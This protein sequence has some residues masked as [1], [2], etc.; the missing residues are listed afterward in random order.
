LKA[1]IDIHQIVLAD[2]SIQSTKI[3]ELL[4][5]KK[6]SLQ[7]L[8]QFIRPD[9]YSLLNPLEIEVKNCDLII[10]QSLSSDLN[11]FDP[12]KF[13][14]AISQTLR[15]NLLFSLS[16]EMHLDD[17]PIRN[18]AELIDAMSQ[19]NETFRLMNF[20]EMQSA[21]DQ[22]LVKNDPR[23]IGFLRLMAVKATKEKKD[24]QAIEFL[25][26]ALLIPCNDDERA[27]LYNQLAKI[28]EK[29]NNW[30][31][32]LECY[33]NIISMIQLSETSTKLPL[34]HI[35]AAIIYGKNQDDH[36]A[37]VHY[38]RGVQLYCQYQSPHHPIV[39]SYKIVIGLK[40][41]KL[42]DMD[43]ALKTFQEVIELDHSDDVKVAYKHISRIYILK[44]DYDMAYYN[45]IESLKVAQREISPDIDFIIDIH[46][47]LARVEFV[48]RHFAEGY[49]H[50]EE[51][52]VMS[53]NNECTEATREEIQSV[54]KMFSDL[55][56][57]VRSHNRNGSKNS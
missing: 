9:D 31:A 22:I 6:E 27:T 53:E 18:P 35:G 32:A 15:Q 14:E 48:R 8:K 16:N 19:D 45:L 20:E 38:K 21:I 36:N 50:M 2:P 40:F 30:P 34:A 46:L 39:S 5:K 54:V 57:F 12:S 23:R 10:E 28:Y 47:L 43:A 44:D 3:I 24:D 51:A 25:R 33:E 41:K 7:Q 26:N 52:R 29:Q 13:L 55:Q 1:N 11:I 56:C 42:G 4:Y 37:I 17:S 49:V